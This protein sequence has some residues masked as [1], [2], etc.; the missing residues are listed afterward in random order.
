MSVEPDSLP[1]WLHWRALKAI[2]TVTRP[3]RAEF[4]ARWGAPAQPVKLLG[5][6]DTWP[7]N[8]R[9]S[10]D[11]F[12]RRFGACN[13]NV[14]AHGSG[15][16]KVMSLAEYLAG[17]ETRAGRGADYLKDWVFSEQA[18]ELCDDYAVPELFPCYFSALDPEL[19]P[20][21]RWIY[22]GPRDSASNFHRDVAGTSAWNALIRGRKLWLFFPPNDTDF[23]N[24]LDAFA[25][26][27]QLATVL[28]RQQPTYCIQEPGEVI[29]TPSQWWHQVYNLEPSLAVTENFVDD[30]NL[31]TVLKGL[32]ANPNWR[33]TALALALHVGSLSQRT[34]G[35]K[36]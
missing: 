19:R 8:T 16:L 32:R 24:L 14:E 1:N 36:G 30:C 33:D 3:S 5:L 2:D 25:P 9:W 12:T 7:A 23:N 6:T 17:I 35:V 10:F 15:E 28:A 31:K 18:P 27:A 11:S 29:F 4:V 21:F 13:V 22:I 20:T 34:L 26:S